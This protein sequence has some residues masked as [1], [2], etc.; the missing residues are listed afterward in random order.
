MALLTV[1]A[2]IQAKEGSEDTV[3]A[4][5]RKLVAPTRA[6]AGCVTYDLHRSVE[7]PTVF[8]FHEIWESRHLLETHLT[9]P[10]MKR[11]L[12]ATDGLIADWELNLLEKIA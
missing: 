10:H 12:A 5:L 9:S 6:E 11:Y 7:D 8:V 4:E 3:A 2:K 1:V